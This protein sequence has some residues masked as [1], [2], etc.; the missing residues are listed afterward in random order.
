MRY[1]ISIA[2]FPTA[3][4][5]GYARIRRKDVLAIGPIRLSIHRVSGTLDDYRKEAS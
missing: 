5:I 3:W 4:E 1:G 2:I